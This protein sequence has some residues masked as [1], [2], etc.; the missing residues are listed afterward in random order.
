M[1]T[2]HSQSVDAITDG[3]P[4]PTLPKHPGKLRH[5]LIQDTHR[6]LTANTASIESPRHGGQNIHLKIVLTTTQ[7][8]FVSRDPFIRPTNPG[9]TPSILAWTTPSGEKAPLREHAKQR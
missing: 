8:S 5:R 2:A 4:S 6:L 3:F 7:Y 9:R 1:Y